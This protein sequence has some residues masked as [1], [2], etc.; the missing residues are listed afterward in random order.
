[1]QFTKSQLKTFDSITS[2]DS[3]HFSSMGRN[4]TEGYQIFTPEFIVRDMC[5]AIGDEIFDFSKTV[6][7]PTSGDSAFTT[8]ILRKRLETII[9]DFKI[10]SL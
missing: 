6:L 4:D 10:E 9:D 8:Y 2:F 7:E 5:T 3:L 1:M